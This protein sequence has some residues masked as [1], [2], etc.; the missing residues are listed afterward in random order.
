MKI[1]KFFSN[2]VESEVSMNSYIDLYGL[3]KDPDYNIKYKFTK[4]DDFTHAFILNTYQPILNIPKENVI[5]LAF[6]PPYFLNI[7]NNFIKYAQNNIGKYFLGSKLNLP[8]PF[9]SHYCCLPH[10]S[11][12]LEKPD[13]NKLMSIMVSQKNRAPGHQYRHNLVKAI[14]KTNLPIDIC[15]RGCEYY[16]HLNDK[17][18]KGTFEINDPHIEYKFHIA[19]ENF[20]TEYYFSEKIV[21]AVA[22]YC[23]PIYYGAINID[24]YIDN[25]IKLT[26]NVSTDI[27]L[28]TEI[29]NNPN[30][31]Y[32]IPDLNSI[33]E[34]ISI[35]NIINEFN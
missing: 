15:G 33:N 28:L 21:N 2:F 26:G 31:Y 6:E 22:R 1:I 9:I 16:K 27:K 32:K 25:V 8:D 35:K 34:K 14:L 24:N 23:R 30:N 29:C 20:V 11:L 3:D 19:I 18:I 7:T 4:D 12:T 10:T 17:R 13:K 5:G